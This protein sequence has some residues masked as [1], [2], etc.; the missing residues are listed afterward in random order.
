MYIMEFL[1]HFHYTRVFTRPVKPTFL[2]LTTLRRYM[3]SSAS[4][5]NFRGT[6]SSSRYIEFNNLLGTLKHCSYHAK[7]EDIWDLLRDA[8]NK[9]ECFR[10]NF[11]STCQSLQ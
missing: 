7:K 2:T 8:N 9:F 11:M 5:P 6:V 4:Q 1:R 3:F 10:Y